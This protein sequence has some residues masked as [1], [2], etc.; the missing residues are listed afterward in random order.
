[1]N[2]IITMLLILVGVIMVFLFNSLHLENGNIILYLI[3]VFVIGFF[4]GGFSNLDNIEKRDSELRFYKRE[5]ANAKIRK[6]EMRLDAI[7]NY[8]NVNQEL[9]RLKN[10]KG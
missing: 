5:I 7:R 4:G 1:M 10:E 9:K 3:S 6:D 2:K 8:D